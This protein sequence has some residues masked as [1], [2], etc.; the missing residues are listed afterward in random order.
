MKRTHLK[1]RGFTLTELMIVVAIAA[2]FATLAVPAMGGMI[3]RQRVQ[4]QANEIANAFSFAHTEA[5]RRGKPVFV[6]PGNVRTDGKLNGSATSWGNANALLVFTDNGA[7]NQTYDAGE[8][9]RVVTLNDKVSLGSP[10]QESLGAALSG[11][12]GSTNMSFVYYSNGQMRIGEVGSDKKVSATQPPG[13]IGRIVVQDPKR[14]TKN[15]TARFCEVIRVD[16]TGRASVYTGKRSDL[17]NKETDF[18]YCESK[19]E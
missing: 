3:A 2:V 19:E 16:A 12:S 4:G 1:Q 10:T 9:L 13:A 15:Q 7:N 5:V 18:F 11:A 6:V 8:D 14:V 17:N